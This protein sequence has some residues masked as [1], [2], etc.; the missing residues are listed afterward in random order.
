MLKLSYSFWKRGSNFFVHAME[1]LS[2][3]KKI[4]ILVMRHD[5]MCV[6]SEKN[7]LYF[8]CLLKFRFL[9]LVFFSL[10]NKNQFQNHVYVV[11]NVLSHLVVCQFPFLFLVFSQYWSL[12]FLKKKK[13]F[14]SN[15]NSVSFVNLFDLFTSPW[16][17]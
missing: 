9:L 12:Q 13:N 1:F 5:L 6:G 17:L 10:K 15:S 14:I 8:S 16:N 7:T 4:H 11:Q 2:F 3:Y